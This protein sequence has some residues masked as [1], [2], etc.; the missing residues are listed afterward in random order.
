MLDLQAGIHFHEEETV[1]PQALGTIGD[2][3]HRAG[4]EI[5]H[6]T[7]GLDR[8]LAEGSADLVGHARGRRLLDDLLVPALHRAVP[9]EE[10][11]DVA[12]LVAEDLHFD[13][14]RCGDVALDQH[15]RIA[16]GIARLALAG[17]QGLLEI[18]MLVDAPHALAAATG[19]GL[20]QHG[21]ADLVGLLAQERRVLD[22][23]VIARHHRH[24]GLLDERLGGI[25]QPHRP[26]G[27]GRRP[28]EHNP[29]DGTGL[30]EIGVLREKAI[31]GMQAF[32][33]APA[34]HVEDP[35]R[36]EIAL[37]RW[38][39]ADI[40]GFVG[41]GHERGL[42]IGIGMDRDHAHA[43]PSRGPGDAECDFTAIGNQNA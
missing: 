37:P 41:I 28:D 29:R 21:I 26:H 23:A 8:R 35:F 25:L 11:E 19:H 10:M 20:D 24:P 32:R 31:A 4:A 42:R 16:E 2:E 18:G 3:F 12:V 15:A 34:R 33:P 38:R 40:V 5:P 17:G 1:G 14:P 9:L 36:H 13:M 22:L 43:H 27:G 30:G 39:G 7:P 6:R